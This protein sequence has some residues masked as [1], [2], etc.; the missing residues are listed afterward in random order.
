M[1]DPTSLPPSPP[2]DALVDWGPRPVERQSAEERMVARLYDDV[3]VLRCPPLR[4]LVRGWLPASSLS[5]VVGPPGCGK[6]LLLIGGG[7]AVASGQ[8][9]LGRTV[10]QPGTVIYVAQEGE[11]GVP[12]R[13]RAAKVDLGLDLASVIGFYTL[14]APVN[15][16]DPASVATFLAII[17]GLHPV[18]IIV[19]TLARAMTGGDEN[20]ARDL[21]LVVA[22]CDHIRARTRAAITLVHHLNAAETRERGSSALRGAADALLAV[23]KTDDLLELS[24][25]KM[26]DAP[27]FAPVRLTLTPVAGTDGATVAL[28]DEAPAAGELTPAQARAFRILTTSFGADGASRAEW[29]AAAPGLA[30]ATFYR[31]V[32]ALAERHLVTRTG[33]RYRPAGGPR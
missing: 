25:L 24:C 7:V 32:H 27:P 9:W 20:S 21:G 23:T 17:D 4:A 10:D 33:T 3:G 26:K 1:R 30:P 11:A 12:A 5:A 19:D 6:S 13:V 28:A 15:L 8:P 2:A 14:A 16:L 29:L 31:C 22:H 18:W